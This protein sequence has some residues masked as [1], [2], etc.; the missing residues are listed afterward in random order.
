MYQ[1]FGSNFIK[2]RSS[3]FSSEGAKLIKNTT[4][5]HNPIDML[6]RKFICKIKTKPICT[7]IQVKHQTLVKEIFNLA[8]V[9]EGFIN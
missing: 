4:L 8:L 1:Y 5:H 7:R 6:I 3:K 2:I 9:G